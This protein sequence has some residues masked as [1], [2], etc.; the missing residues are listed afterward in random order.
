MGSSSQALEKIQKIQTTNQIK[1]RFGDG[2]NPSAMPCLLPRSTTMK[3]HFQL[4]Q[5]PGFS[6]IFRL[7]QSQRTNKKHMA[8]ST[9]G[10]HEWTNKQKYVNMRVYGIYIPIKNIN[11]NININI[12]NNIK[13]TYTCTDVTTDVYDTLVLVVSSQTG[14]LG[15]W[16][17][18]NATGQGPKLY[19]V[20]AF[21][22][23]QH[24]QS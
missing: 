6:Q 3:T 8:R 23:C 20:Q 9:Q 10:G 14:Q 15:L 11:M 22:T 21:L 4:S 2:W 12:Y 19:P 16:D 18:K 24:L 17:W 13:Y 1:L 7:L 5:G